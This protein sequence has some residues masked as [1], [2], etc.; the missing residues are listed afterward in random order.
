MSELQ[1]NNSI[2]VNGI[3][4]YPEDEEEARYLEALNDF[5]QRLIVVELPDELANE[6]EKYVRRVS[7]INC[8]LAL[9][10]HEEKSM[11]GL[12]DGF[13]APYDTM[14]LWEIAVKNSTQMSEINEEASKPDMNTY[15]VTSHSGRGLICC[16]EF[17]NSMCEK[18]DSMRL[19]VSMYHDKD[20]K[21]FIFIT[22][23]DDKDKM[24]MR[25]YLHQ[26]NK[27]EE[28]RQNYV[29]VRNVGMLSEAALN[30]KE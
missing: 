21:T 8:I 18:F 19:I 17:W 12:P 26:A 15:V 28:T 22:P 1:D 10:N 6:C 13:E 3:P 9:I 23:L 2:D 20:D 30:S 11:S 27:E 4:V 24:D 7:G 14:T 16:D 29:F 5:N 25:V